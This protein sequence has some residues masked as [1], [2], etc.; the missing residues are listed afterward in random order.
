[1]NTIIRSFSWSA[2]LASLL[3]ISAAVRAQAIGSP[4]LSPTLA[5]YTPNQHLGLDWEA[6]AADTTAS[7]RD[8]VALA[9][10][11]LLDL[12]IGRPSSYAV[13]V[14]LYWT[15]INERPAT[16]FVVERRDDGQASYRAVAVLPG[17]GAGQELHSYSFVDDGN[18][19]KNSCSYRLRQVCPGECLNQL[20]AVQVVPGATTAP[21]EP[22]DSPATPGPSLAVD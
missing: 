8:S 12:R 5:M 22:K 11:A 16:R 9:R 21:P 20:S 10:P 3:L 14:V 18:A 4:E 7:S 6:T 1:M 19:E 13:G 2:L 17:Q 15:S